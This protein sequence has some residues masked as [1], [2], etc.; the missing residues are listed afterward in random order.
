MF[1]SPRWVTEAL[2]AAFKL[3]FVRLLAG[4]VITL[5]QRYDD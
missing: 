3:A 4:A 5:D 1:V 2:I